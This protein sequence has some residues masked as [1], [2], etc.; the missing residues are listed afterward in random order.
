MSIFY[1]TE[2]NNSFSKRVENY[3]KRKGAKTLIKDETYM[4]I[5]QYLS[6]YVVCSGRKH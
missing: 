1:L 2:N 5:G 3:G 6:K 4:A